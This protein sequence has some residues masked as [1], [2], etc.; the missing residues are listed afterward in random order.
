MIRSNS[1]RATLAVAATFALTLSA[2]NEVHA[3]AGLFGTQEVKRWN[4]CDWWNIPDSALRR[5]ERRSDYADIL[6]RM[7]DSCPDAA[8]ALTDRPTATSGGSGVSDD[9]RGR[10][11]DTND[12]ED[13]GDDGGNPGGSGNPGGG[14]N[15]GPGGDEPSDDDRSNDGSPNGPPSD[16]PPSTG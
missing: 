13:G 15:G 14:G 7:F 1:T 3:Q 8:L 4:M 6:R 2:P 9:Q 5:I 10:E 11:S 12:D 16:N